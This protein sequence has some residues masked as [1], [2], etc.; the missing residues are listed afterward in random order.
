MFKKLREGMPSG[1]GDKLRTLMIGINTQGQQ[2]EE[3][4]QIRKLGLQIAGMARKPGELVAAIKGMGDTQAF[5]DAETSTWLSPE[6]IA[7]GES[8]PFEAC[9]LLAWLEIAKKAGVPAI[10]AKVILR[11]TDAESEAVSGIARIPTGAIPDRI[12]SR[13]RQGIE[14][15]REAFD[16]LLTA[17]PE[18][19][20]AP[21]DMEE[22]VEKVYACMD[23]LPEGW[24]VRS[25][26]T[27]PSTLKALA[28]TGLVEETAP[29][30]RFGP[31]LEVGPG[32]VRNGNRRRVDTGDRR[33]M[34]GYVQG[35]HTGLIYVARPWVQASR[36]VEGRD[37]HREGTPID[38]PG[39]W[40]AEWR[41]FVKGRRVV[42]VSSYYCWL[43]TPTPQTAHIACQVRDLAQRIV[44]TAVAQG[45]EPRYMDVE[46]GRR[47]PETAQMLEDQG[48]G[49]GTFS[50]TLD[51][52]ETAQGI[53]LL[54]GG[55]GNTPLGG[56][57]PC[58][59]AGV[60][61]QPRLA[62]PMDTTG[63]A[64]RHMP[65][66][67]IGEPKTWVEGDKDGCILDW[68]AVEALAKEDGAC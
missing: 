48:F 38:V 39:Q 65:H 27:G 60:S 66:V 34:Q 25:N 8:G 7:A 19:Q 55:P 30:A 20:Q 63:V 51:F 50:C 61:G 10:P 35:P 46:H 49:R 52:M 4:G 41:A 40:P 9:S 47:N 67:L 18:D 54:E 45:L 17:E 56:G 68:D 3:A 5:H 15:D 33:I 58:G 42:G 13:M 32:W 2:Q 44:D 28:C 26:Q 16:A 22:L 53:V 1:F 21:V 31:G 37:P 43:E 59:F 64:F 6:A 11:L 29:E 14:Q 23:D 24:M 36:Y 12:R 57:H 62:N